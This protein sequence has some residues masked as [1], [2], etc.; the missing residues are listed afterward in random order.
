[1]KSLFFFAFIEIA[2]FFNAQPVSLT[3]FEEDDK[4]KALITK[5]EKVNGGW[6]HLASK[7]NVEFTYT[8]KD[9]AKG[10]DISKERYIFNG[11]VSW[12][13]YSKHE[14]NVF[15]KSD[16]HAMQLY[17][18]GNTHTTLG[19][20]SVDDKEALFMATFLRKANFFWFCM[21]YKLSDPGVVAK[22][23]GKEKIKDINYDKVSITYESAQTGKETNDE[24]ILYF[25]PKTHLVDQFYFSL[26]LIGVQKPILRMEL[27]Y[28][29]IEGVHIATTR[30]GVFPNEKG[31]YQLAGL[32]TISDLQFN[33]RFT[34]R[35]SFFILAPRIYP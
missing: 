34:V 13:D 23:L 20:K 18:Q 27:Q 2:I 33:N 11:E 31:E 24:F 25:N 21:M 28:E 16:L 35:L 26:P 10:I 14:V 17:A 15:P 22:Y 8:Y 1:M 19:G 3:I 29:V 4:A 30:K 9:M 5:L 7:K 12:G 6:K 32:Y